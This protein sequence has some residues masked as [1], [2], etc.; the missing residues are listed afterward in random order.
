MMYSNT[1]VSSGQVDD[2]CCSVRK[3]GAA[4][5]DLDS[6][7]PYCTA[8]RIVLD[9]GG[10][11]MNTCL[12]AYDMYEFYTSFGVKTRGIWSLGVILMAV[13]IMILIIT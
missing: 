11:S 13:V 5:K 1:T 3:F 8:Q 9:S 12:L 10:S 7:Y 2:L 6:G 4:G